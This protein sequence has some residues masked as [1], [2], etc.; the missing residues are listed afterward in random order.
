VF[1]R[2]GKYFLLPL[3]GELRIRR[4]Q[5]VRG[6]GVRVGGERALKTALIRMTLER[7]HRRR[8]RKWRY[9]EAAGLMQKPT[10]L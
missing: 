4:D 9:S 1:K 5:S 3:D 6:W 8:A 10:S 7:C 2:Q